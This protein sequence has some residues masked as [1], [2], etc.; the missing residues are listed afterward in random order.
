MSLIIFFK[1]CF[2]FLYKL[3]LSL[4]RFFNFFFNFLQI[5]HLPASSGKQKSASSKPLRDD[6]WQNFLDMLDN[7]DDDWALT[8][9]YIYIE[10]K[11][12]HNYCGKGGSGWGGG[13]TGGSCLL[14]KSFFLWTI[15]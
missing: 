3:L 9:I 10:Y 2:V 8:D 6:Q 1:F 12:G 7:A 13:G 5:W 15:R 11:Q 14:L 4:L